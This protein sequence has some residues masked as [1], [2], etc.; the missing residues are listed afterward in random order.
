MEGDGDGF[1]WR[2]LWCKVLSLFFLWFD[3]FD[4]NLCWRIEV[5]VGMLLEEVFIV[6]NVL[7]V[8]VESWWL[9]FL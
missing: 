4:V 2:F 9:D 5:W 8:E 1:I 6:V 3:F 7:V